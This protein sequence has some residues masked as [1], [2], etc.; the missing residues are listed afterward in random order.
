[1]A[2]GE[3]QEG[4][5]DQI[6][7]RLERAVDPSGN[8]ARASDLFRKQKELAEELAGQFLGLQVPNEDYPLFLFE[9]PLASV[10]FA[11]GFQKAIAEWSRE[12]EL[13][14]AFRAAIHLAKV[15]VDKEFGIDRSIDLDSIVIPDSEKQKL[16]HLDSLAQDN[17]ILLTRLAFNRARAEMMGG[18]ETLKNTLWMEHGRYAIKGLDSPLEVCEVGISGISRLSP[19]PESDQVTRAMTS[20]RIATLGWRPAVGSTIPGR[21]NW[22]L[23]NKLGESENGEVWLA[24]QN[25]T[26]LL[27]AFKF[28]FDPSRL[29]YLKKEIALLQIIRDN[30]GERPDIARIYDVQ[31]DR[32]PY[33]LEV[34]YSADGTL[35]HW[36]EEKGGGKKIPLKR[37]LEV[38]AQISEALEAAHS[39]GIV[40]KAVQPSNILIEEKKDQT[41]RARLTDFG[42]GKL[43]DTALLEEMGLSDLSFTTDELL[44]MQ[45]QEGA[46]SASIYSAPEVAAGGT[47]TPQSDIFSL[48]VLLYQMTLGDID[49]PISEDWDQSDTDPAL[50]QIIQSATHSDPKRRIQTSS[51]LAKALREFTGP[52]KQEAP[53]TKDR[54]IAEQESEEEKTLA[55]EAED[56]PQE[57]YTIGDYTVLR[58]I[59]EGG[60]GA[61]YLGKNPLTPDRHF[62]IKVFTPS[63]KDSLTSTLSDELQHVL[64]LVHEYIVQVRGFGVAKGKKIDESYL[65][66]DYIEGPNGSSYNLKNYIVEKGGRLEEKEVRRIFLQILSALCSV[67]R[68][69]IAHLD[70]KPQNILMDKEYNAY[71]S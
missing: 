67:H 58:K 38:V 48:G 66:M 23:Q 34:D 3:N 57:E 22:T 51:E 45:E 28:I 55:Y 35:E 54:P 62:A 71:V 21:A 25:S 16:N 59:G 2:A 24:Q 42:E 36:W 49:L 69:R 60:F 32:A 8:P 43:V 40:H 46:P 20:H 50:A 26:H 33:Y 19:P 6:L 14:L 56:T 64:D 63:E 68:K 39:L 70:I 44:Q 12:W 18:E 53:E 29:N 1:M 4:F 30:L 11:L 65:V 17:Q 5:R 13:P 61:V 31:T 41:T 10:H 47:H 37:R 7:L 52:A 15:K 27:H 9:T